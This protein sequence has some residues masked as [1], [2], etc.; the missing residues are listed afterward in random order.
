MAAELV[1]T[2]EAVV[3]DGMMVVA[4]VVLVATV[5]MAEMGPWVQEVEVELAAA[6]A[7]AAALEITA[8]LVVVSDFLEL[9]NQ[10]LVVQGRELEMAH[11][12]AM[13]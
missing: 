6:V 12:V 10:D 4:A 2:V 7:A 1:V 11:A 5:V 13:V 8:A 3:V 9:A